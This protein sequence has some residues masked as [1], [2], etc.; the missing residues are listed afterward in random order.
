MEE[1]LD[2]EDEEWEKPSKLPSFTPAG[3]N[4]Q[5]GEKKEE[6]PGVKFKGLSVGGGLRWDIRR[7]PSPVW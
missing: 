4:I 1:M 5:K 7:H 2:L 6:S 3:L